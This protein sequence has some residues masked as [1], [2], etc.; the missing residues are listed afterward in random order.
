MKDQKP[1]IIDFEDAAEAVGETLK[2]P[3]RWR[4]IQFCGGSRLDGGETLDAEVDLYIDIL[5]RI[6]KYL[7]ERR[8]MVQMVTTAFNPRQLR[9]LRDETILTGYTS[10]IEVLDKDVFNAICPGKAKYIGYDEWK[11]RPQGRW[12]PVQG[13]ADAK[14]LRGSPKVRT[15]LY[16]SYLPAGGGSTVYLC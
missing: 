3:G 12:G 16:S 8:A 7:P 15:G 14:G 10:D 13:G 2:Q 9:R 5:K 1:E 11:N 6:E 4:S